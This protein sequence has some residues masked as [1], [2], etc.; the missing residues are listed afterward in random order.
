MY[1]CLTV[2]NLAG[3]FHKESALKIA[4]ISKQSSKAF[5]KSTTAETTKKRI[6]HKKVF[7]I[8]FHILLA[9][10]NYRGAHAFLI[11]RHYPL[12]EPYTLSPNFAHC[13][14]EIVVVH[15]DTHALS[16]HFKF[17]A[18]NILDSVHVI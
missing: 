5:S 7:S 1:F 8:Y 6:L 11:F 15:H 14:I 2:F 17:V 4:N 3:E 16:A 18:K 9:K 10:Q 13:F 12:C